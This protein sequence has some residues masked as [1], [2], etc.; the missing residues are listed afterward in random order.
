MPVRKAD[1]TWNGVLQTGEGTMA[2]ESGA[3]E[4]AYSYGT[5]FGDDPGTNPEE[6]IGAAHA[7]CFSM[8]YANELDEAGYTPESVSTEASVHLEGG[9]ITRIHLD[10]EAT[11]PDID[12]ETFREIATAAKEGCPVSGALAA[13]DELTLDAAL[14]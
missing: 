13:V 7:G 2:V 1:A 12:E 5:R 14:A 8:A 10:C 6:L 3:Y 11:V 9:E 4:G